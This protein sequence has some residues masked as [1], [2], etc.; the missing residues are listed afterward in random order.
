VH[1]SLERRFL[2]SQAAS[3][4]MPQ[5]GIMSDHSQ[6]AA[7]CFYTTQVSQLIFLFNS[8]TKAKRDHPFLKNKCG[9]DNEQ[10]EKE[11]RTILLTIDSKQLKHLGINLT[12][13]VTTYMVNII[14]H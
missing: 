6:H 13:E 8:V 4:P 14:N 7:L 12:K 11:I 5:L 1:T 10:C 2:L 3:L 9:T